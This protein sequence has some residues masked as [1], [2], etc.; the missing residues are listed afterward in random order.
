[1]GEII[2]NLRFV[3]YICNEMRSEYKQDNGCKSGG[4]INF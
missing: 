2:E 4:V 1:M 3:L